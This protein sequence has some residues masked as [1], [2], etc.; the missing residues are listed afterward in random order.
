M[1]GV[2]E[3]WPSPAGNWGWVSWS[4]QTA[5]S[6]NRIGG[7]GLGEHN[8]PSLAPCSG[9]FGLSRAP[10]YHPGG[11]A[12]PNAGQGAPH[13]GFCSGEEPTNGAWRSGQRR[14]VPETGRQ[15]DSSKIRPA[16]TGR[17]CVGRGQRRPPGLSG[18]R[19][20]NVGSSCTGT[21]LIKQV[22]K[23]RLWRTACAPFW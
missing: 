6:E 5:R 19:S 18:I 15:R 11:A 9:G 17:I 12:G 3:D 10:F 13:F 4:T 1:R 14:R 21:S 23:G 22:D 8:S 20:A 2:G 16:P 7:F